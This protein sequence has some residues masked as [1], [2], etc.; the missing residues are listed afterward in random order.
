MAIIT[1]MKFPLSRTSHPTPLLYHIFLGIAICF[2]LIISQ[3]E[4]KS[5]KSVKL[6]DSER[7]KHCSAG[8]FSTIACC[9][10]RFLFTNYCHPQKLLPHILYNEYNVNFLFLCCNEVGNVL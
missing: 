1:S 4:Q 10:N 6:A 2:L 7:K 9:E 5:T 3:N 8:E